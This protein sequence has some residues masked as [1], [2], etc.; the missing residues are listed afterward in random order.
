MT[1]CMLSDEG[2]EICV[3]FFDVRKAFD[4]VPHIELLN[5]LEEIGLP[6]AIVRWFKNYLTGSCSVCGY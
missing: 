4:S 6:P 1:G 3:I 2:Y 5:R